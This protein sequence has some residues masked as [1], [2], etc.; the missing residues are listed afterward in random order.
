MNT[1]QLMSSHRFAA[2]LG[3]ILCSVAFLP[4]SATGQGCVAARH[5]SLNLSD[6]GLHYHDA[7]EW[8]GTFNYRWLQSDHHFRGDHDEGDIRYARGN[9]VINDTHGFDLTALYAFNARFSAALTIPFVYNTRSSLYEHDRVNRHSSS[10]GGLADLRLLA[11]GWL[12]DPASHADGNI[13]LGLGVKAP[14]GDYAATS[15]FYT[16]GGA[17]ERPVDQSIQPGDGG[18]GIVMEVHGAQKV[19]E[20]GFLYLSG[21][22]LSNPQETNGTRTYRETLS[23]TLANEAIMSVADQFFG[24][25]G[26]SYALWPKKSLY[27]NLGV[28]AEGV[29]VHDLIGG[30]D[31]FRRPGIMISVEPGISMDVKGWALNLTTPVAVYRNRW[32][33]VTDEAMDRHGDAA[34]PDWYLNFSVTRRF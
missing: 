23:P 21:S 17:E 14:T 20:N 31:G 7:G 25:A 4:T 33:S 29:P 22:Y 10:A 13:A 8:T 19:M 16:A 24:R 34:F 32:Q 30:D 3:S 9:E 1:K 11:Y 27:L 6:G 5:T 12:L 18:W 28:R 26:M 2:G 15:L